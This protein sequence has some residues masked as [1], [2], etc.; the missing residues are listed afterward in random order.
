M[1]RYGEGEGAVFA[2]SAG[3]AKVQ[4]TLVLVGLELRQ[5]ACSNGYQDH[6]YSSYS[7]LNKALFIL[8]D[9]A[10]TYLCCKSMVNATVSGGSN[11]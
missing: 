8:R 6:L 1:I 5:H 10:S 2:P 11:T 9:F 4:K 7:K 3:N